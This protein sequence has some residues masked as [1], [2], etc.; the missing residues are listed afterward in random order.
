MTGPRDA[1]DFVDTHVHFWDQRHEGLRYDWLRTDGD[2]AETAVLGEYGAVRAEKYLPEDFLRETR[3]ARP[4]QVVHV[5][6]ALGTED[7]VRESAW[8]DECRR[9]TG[10]PDA[11]VGDARLVSDDLGAVVEGHGMFPGFRGIRDLRLSEYLGDPRCDR[12]LE[13]L[14][15]AGLVLCD[16]DALH[17]LEATVAALKRHPDLVYCVDHTMM[18]MRRDAEYA[19]EWRAAL[20]RV[21]AAPGAVVKIS[22]LGQTDH[23]WT[24]E[25]WRPWIH[26]CLEMFGTE[27][28][29]FGTNWPVD[30][31]YSSYADVVDAYVGACA[32]LSAHE[33]A[34]V[35]AD[36]ARRIF[37][38]GEEILD[39]DRQ[40]PAAPPGT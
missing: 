34:A 33:R 13:L 19:R 8:L 29:V 18:P 5:Q 15:R 26:A 10:I 35:F 7:P 9:R 25:S 12:G 37:G 38:I 6:A 36:N 16:S 3:S 11:F 21:A 17:R 22:G 1:V 31:L 30:R 20:A 39:E 2:P 40:R 14:A 27:R 23:D 24:P 28:V 4:S 32:D